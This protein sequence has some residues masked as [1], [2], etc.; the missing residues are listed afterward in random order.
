[1]TIDDR[2]ASCGETHP[3]LP[4]LICKRSPHPYG[5]HL[6]VVSQTM[7]PGKPEPVL[8]TPKPRGAHVKEIV[9]KVIASGAAAVT[10]PPDPLAMRP[11]AT[12]APL[13]PWESE[14]ERRR[15]EWLKEAKAALQRVAQAQELFMVSDVWLQV[16]NTPSR[17]AMTL[18]VQFGL[19]NGW[20]RE[21]GARRVTEN[22][23][24][25]DGVSFPLN[26]LCPI[27]KSLIF[28]G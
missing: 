2:P 1:M 16:D 11:G 23:T 3:D 13:R 14:W 5:P 24:T 15:P 7:W 6:D 8:P 19:R 27:Y 28:P 25:R 18:V 4:Q 17:R 26:K 10:G 21:D 22:W 20:M 9:D 12:S